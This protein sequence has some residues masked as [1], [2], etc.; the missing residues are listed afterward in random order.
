VLPAASNQAFRNPNANRKELDEVF[1][2]LV[3]AAQAKYANNVEVNRTRP[4]RR[5]RPSWQQ[6]PGKS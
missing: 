4:G 6:T 2:V 5:S 1:D 3:A